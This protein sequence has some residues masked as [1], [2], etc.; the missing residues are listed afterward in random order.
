MIDWV[1]A[2]S[3]PM[4]QSDF[5]MLLSD[6]LKAVGCFEKHWNGAGVLVKLRLEFLFMN[7]LGNFLMSEKKKKR[8]NS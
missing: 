3:V 8:L 4:G 7:E 2:G 6:L 5:M 1:L